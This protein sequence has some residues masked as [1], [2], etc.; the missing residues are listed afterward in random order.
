MDR[1]Y[2][3]HIE[4]ILEIVRSIGTAALPIVQVLE[5]VQDLFRKMRQGKDSDEAVWLIEEKRQLADK[6]ATLQN[7]DVSNQVEH[8]TKLVTDAL[9]KVQH[10]VEDLPRH[11][12]LEGAARSRDD[13][14]MALQGLRTIVEGLPKCSELEQVVKSGESVALVLEK[15]RKDSEG[16]AQGAK[17]DELAK[18]VSTAIKDVG[19]DVKGLAQGAK[20]DEVAEGGQRIATAVNEIRTSVGTL[21]QGAKLDEVAETGQHIAITLDQLRDNFRQVVSGAAESH[22]NGVKA[23]VTT[24]EGYVKVTITENSRRLTEAINTG[25]TE[26]ME[27]IQDMAK[28]LTTTQ[29]KHAATVR[30]RIADEMADTVKAIVGE[31]KHELSL[32]TDT[33]KVIPTDRVS[34]KMDI[35]AIKF[36]RLGDS[37]GES[38][39]KGMKAIQVSS[40][41]VVRSNE[42]WREHHESASRINGLAVAGFAEESRE[43]NRRIRA[44]EQELTVSKAARAESDRSLAE[45]QAEVEDLG[46]QSAKINDLTTRLSESRTK[47][48]ELWNKFSHVN[49]LLEKHR[50]EVDVAKEQA[51]TETEARLQ[52]QERLQNSSALLQT[53]NEKV[54]RLETQAIKLH[55][56]AALAEEFTARMEK[57]LALKYSD[58]DSI[59]TMQKLRGQVSDLT[60][61]LVE[62]KRAAQ[63]AHDNTSKA[64]K[65]S[66]E[67]MEQ[68]QQIKARAYSEKIEASRRKGEQERETNLMKNRLAE[69]AELISK[70]EEANTLVQRDLAQARGAIVDLEADKRSREKVALSDESNS[71]AEKG[72]SKQNA[73]VAQEISVLE[74]DKKA[75][76]ANLERT[77]LELTDKVRTVEERTKIVQAREEVIEK[78]K[79]GATAA[80]DALATKDAEITK[81]QSEI[82]RMR[83]VADDLQAREKVIEKMKM[84]ATAAQ[85]ALAAKDAEI[86]K[87]QTEIE[88]MRKVADDTNIE[89]SRKR[90]RTASPEVPAKKRTFIAAYMDTLADLLNTIPITG[91]EELHTWDLLN[92]ASGL[93]KKEHYRNLVK[94]LKKGALD[95]WFCLDVVMKKGRREAEPVDPNDAGCLVHELSC[96]L[97][98]ATMV[99]SVRHLHFLGT[100]GTQVDMEDT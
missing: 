8:C 37:I 81:Q 80:Q 56:D 63:L 79:M 92:V 68:A 31:F 90:L 88:L 20:L 93:T 53:A 100:A 22:A 59:S 95:T 61:E 9:D 25:H 21:A 12:D 84:G 23:A 48:K 51:R 47:G 2:E 44:L 54:V 42:Y 24:S 32:V 43:N 40:S 11:A 77:R 86:T 52:A 41:E 55:S 27:K 19:T 7:L 85:D 99:D 15:L 34:D 72:R 10:I 75:L 1:R 5:D 16:L 82:K 94:F 17:L 76:E 49:D 28:D 65:K 64:A 69:N 73:T 60:S 83:K 50:H 33:I 36:E 78:M 39:S 57:L 70:L 91:D 89:S 97:V 74:S 6:I 46:Q 87:Q 26:A 30:E 98:M 3:E 18:G 13:T 71:K 29:K 4:R 45:K 96:I 35:L 62:A 67:A 38:I 58:N 14:T 66:A